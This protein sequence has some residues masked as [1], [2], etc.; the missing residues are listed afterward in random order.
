MDGWERNII[1]WR[2][3]I[4]CRPE[5]SGEERET[6]AFVAE[7]LRSFGLQVREGV[8]GYG[9]V[10][11]LPGRADKKC[12]ALRA[13]LDALPI[14]E[15]NDCRY[16]SQVDGVMHACGHDAHTAIVLGAAMLLAENPPAG[17]VK[18]LF[19]PHEETKPGGARGMIA[20]G[21]L[22]NP[23]VDGLFAT[24]V[25]NAYPLGSFGVR[26]GAMMA[27]SDD[28]ML[29]I[30]GKSSHGALPHLSVDAIVLAGQVIGAAQAIVSRRID[31][32][33]PAVISFGSIH[34]GSAPNV[35]AE[36]VR[37]R[38]TVRSFDRAVQEQL[39]QELRR[40]A[41]GVA[42]ALG[43]RAEL[44]IVPGYPPLLNDAGM[45][46]RLRLAIAGVAGAEW[47]PVTEPPLGGEDFAIFC[48]QA[49]SALMFTGTGSSRCQ[50]AWHQP[51]FQI[52][53]AALPLA[54]RVLAAAA[55]GLANEDRCDG[56]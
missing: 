50:A 18:F 15:Q 1:A 39:F 10:G 33:E 56:P 34:G 35:I 45:A 17:A 21:A 26:P 25:L 54:A 32:H 9:V 8:G 44:A 13:D 53:E 36:A 48:E 43:G 23:R 28:F 16:R 19:Q 4:H 5:L 3:R 52:E 6:A 11:L 40:T 55:A 31:P 49:P 29:D 41:E 14:Q 12:A 47:R 24:H 7:L 20:A 42:A 38:G 2:R 22:Q 51:R 37:L 30:Y 46:E 27:A